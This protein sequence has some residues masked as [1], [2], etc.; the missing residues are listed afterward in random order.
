MTEFSENIAVAIGCRLVIDAFS[1][2]SS[3]GGAS[4]AWCASGYSWVKKAV[5]V[6]GLFGRALGALRLY[7]S[8]I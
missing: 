5:E 4:D 2:R 6:V 1:D 7:L 3:V 8:L